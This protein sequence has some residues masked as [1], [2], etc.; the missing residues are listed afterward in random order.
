MQITCP[1]C[2]SSNKA[3]LIVFLFS[4]H[5]PIKCS[6]CEKSFKVKSHTNLVAF[7]L[8]FATIFIGFCQY[9][10]LNLFITTII[11]VFIGS[12]LNLLILKKVYNLET[13]PVIEPPEFTNTQKKG[14]TW[15]IWSL[16]MMAIT[17]TLGYLTGEQS[18][19]KP[20]VLSLIK[21]IFWVFFIGNIVVL[22]IANY[23]FWAERKYPKK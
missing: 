1:A 14:T 13:I 6:K 12:G 2:K 17:A 10:S 22:S 23:Y 5:R 21:K 3:K 7:H 9:L 18:M 8:F 4:P 15:F 19:V 16:V 20:E 11:Y